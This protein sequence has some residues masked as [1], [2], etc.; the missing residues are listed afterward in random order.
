MLIPLDWQAGLLQKIRLKI[1]TLYKQTFLWFMLLLTHA[2]P[3]PTSTFF[4]IPSF[5]LCERV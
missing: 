3:E 5:H 1:N 2:L 4:Y